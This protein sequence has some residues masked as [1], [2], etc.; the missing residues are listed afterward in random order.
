MKPFEKLTS[1]DALEYEVDI[2]GLSD[3][4][5]GNNSVLIYISVD[6]DATMVDANHWDYEGQKLICDRM[7]DSVV[8]L[9]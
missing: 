3:D 6:A 1:T 8:G 7:L 4:S 9:T 2:E 5:P